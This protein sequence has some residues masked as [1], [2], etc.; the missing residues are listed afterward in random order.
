MG[1]GCGWAG[2]AGG[3]SKLLLQN[4]KILHDLA[5]Y[6]DDKFLVFLDA[7]KTLRLLSLSFI[8]K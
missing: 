4:L 1:L 2:E 7:D 6:T 5:Q 3:E 8:Q